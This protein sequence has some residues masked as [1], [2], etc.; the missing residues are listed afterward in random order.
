MGEEKSDRKEYRR[1]WARNK[2]QSLTEEAKE[3]KRASQRAYYAANKEKAKAINKACYEK[4][5]ERDLE[6]ERAKAR[7]RVNKHYYKDLEKSREQARE[8]AKR[9]RQLRGDHHKSVKFKY[10]Y[11]ITIADRDAMFAN[12]GFKCAICKSPDPGSKSGW[13]TDH[14]HKTGIVR[15]ILCSHCNRGLGAFRDNPEFMREAANKIEE[16]YKTIACKN[17]VDA[18]VTAIGEGGKDD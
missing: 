9:R 14:C 6:G 3:K 17:S 15:F 13:N 8:A 12:Q 16:F 4:R 5:R 2:Y 7:A 1:N 18:P 10:Q 11:G